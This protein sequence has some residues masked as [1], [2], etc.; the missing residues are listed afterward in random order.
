[1]SNL[2]SLDTAIRAHYNFIGVS[3]LG[4]ELNLTQAI[5]GKAT[6]WFAAPADLVPV[7][8]SFPQEVHLHKLI[9]N[10]IPFRVWIALCPEL[11]RGVYWAEGFNAYLS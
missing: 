8:M 10:R 6:W 11:K 5:K 9:V 3:L 1:M 2:I 4:W 7:G